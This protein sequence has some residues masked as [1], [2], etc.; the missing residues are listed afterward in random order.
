[1]SLFDLF[2]PRRGGGYRP[3]PVDARDRP[4][5]AMGLAATPPPSASL[6]GFVSSVLDQGNTESCVAHAI[7]SGLRVA[8]RAR[9]RE[10]QLPSRRFLYWHARGYHAGELVDAGTY[11]RTCMKGAVC[12]GSSDETACPW[13]PRLVNRSPGWGAYR[14][15]FDGAGLHGY[16]R[17]DEYSDTRLD[18]IRRAVASQV[19]VAFGTRISQAFKSHTGTGTVTH[20]SDSAAVGGHAMLVVGYEGERF[21]VLNSWG[22][23][24]GDGGFAWLD[25]AYLNW[26]RTQDLWA[27][28][29][30]GGP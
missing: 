24:W 6:A 9:G 22:T 26:P 23:Y 12:F 15:A 28:D 11:L 20:P 16:Y 2:R 18:E 1:M 5:G 13:D 29:V 21:R 14:K 17:I 30:G 7:A 8:H 4:F 19:P 3:D 27:L 25:G 10:V